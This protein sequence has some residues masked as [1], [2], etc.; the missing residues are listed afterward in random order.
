MGE[1]R[2]GGEVLIILTAG[3]L[4]KYVNEIQTFHGNELECSNGEGLRGKIACRLQGGGGRLDAAADGEDR[5]KVSY[6][7]ICFFMYCRSRICIPAERENSFLLK[8]RWGKLVPFEEKVGKRLVGES[9]ITS[10]LSYQ[11]LNAANNL[12]FYCCCTCSMY[13]RQK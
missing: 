12:N 1:R 13:S 2:G 9:K 8:K 7:T 3:S 10:I 5:L 4:F 6:G 11:F